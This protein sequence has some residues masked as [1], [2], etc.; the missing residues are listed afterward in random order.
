MLPFSAFYTDGFQTQ[1]CRPD[2]PVRV[3]RPFALSHS[4][5]RKYYQGR[6]NAPIV[7]P[8]AMENGE[9]AADD[10]CVLTH[11]GT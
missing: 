11:G 10:V 2:F 3:G 6:A 5:P 4:S 9:Q 7:R 8:N 1:Y